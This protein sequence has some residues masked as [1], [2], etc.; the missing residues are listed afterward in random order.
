M[1]IYNIDSIPKPKLPIEDACRLA[2]CVAIL[3]AMHDI[4]FGN[5]IVGGSL[6]I[7]GALAAISPSFSKDQSPQT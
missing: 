7:I 1:K 5:P 6:T 2:G 4:E 3:K